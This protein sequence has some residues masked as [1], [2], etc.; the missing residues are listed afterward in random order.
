MYVRELLCLWILYT[1][2]NDPN[3][4]RD[5]F[6]TDETGFLE[7]TNLHNQHQWA[8][9]KFPHPTRQINQQI[10][11]VNVWAGIINDCVMGPYICT[12]GLRE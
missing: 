1:I 12:R 4:L 11:R 8:E 9:E 6:R 10:F 5:I 3:F 7:I 2:L